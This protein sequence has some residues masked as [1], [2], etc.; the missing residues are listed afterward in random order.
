MPQLGYKGMG[1]VLHTPTTPKDSFLVFDFSIHL[2]I[3]KPMSS[4]DRQLIVHHHGTMFDSH[5]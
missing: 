3:A 4:C 1:W 2:Y 5:V